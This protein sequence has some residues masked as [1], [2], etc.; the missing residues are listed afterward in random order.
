MTKKN[1]LQWR[2]GV[3]YAENKLS[4]FVNGI[5]F[6]FAEVSKDDD[7]WQ[8]YFSASHSLLFKNTSGKYF[9]TAEEAKLRA[10]E[11]LINIFSSF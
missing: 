4:A 8:I 9:E 5:E 6:V 10:Q 2:N 3:E 11:I 7:F 1:K